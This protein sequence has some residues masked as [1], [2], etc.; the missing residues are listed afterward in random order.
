MSLSCALIIKF[1]NVI[2]HG[3]VLLA[4]TTVIEQNLATV[5]CFLA[6]VLGK[7]LMK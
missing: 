7:G 2:T 1:L 4:G 6:I 3:I 5:T